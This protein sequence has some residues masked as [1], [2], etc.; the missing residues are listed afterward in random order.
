MLQIDLIGELQAAAFGD[1]PHRAAGRRQRGHDLVEHRVV[2]VGRRDLAPRELGDFVD[3]SLDLA[4]R[5]LDLFGVH[6]RASAR[7]P[8]V[9]EY[10]DVLT[11][12]LDATRWRGGRASK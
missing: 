11:S 12:V 6:R 9:W 5:A 7:V 1:R 10:S 2:E 8:E 4:L 3:E